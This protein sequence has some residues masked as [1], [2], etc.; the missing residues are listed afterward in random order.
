MPDY[1]ATGTNR[2]HCY[3]NIR[4]KRLKNNNISNPCDR[5]DF[6]NLVRLS[7]EEREL[8]AGNDTKT[9]RQLELPRCRTLQNR[10]YGRSL[11]K[12]FAL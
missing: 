6:P 2:I 10:R 12:I 5:S 1:Q 3:Y 7:A 9:A 8:P 11:I 4:Q